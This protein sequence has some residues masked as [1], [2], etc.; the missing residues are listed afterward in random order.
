MQHQPPNMNTEVVD[1]IKEQVGEELG[2]LIVGE[3]TH[4]KKDSPF[5]S[6]KEAEENKSVKRDK[7]KPFKGYPIINVFKVIK[8]GYSY[9]MKNLERSGHFFIN[10]I[11]FLPDKKHPKEMKLVQDGTTTE[12]VTEVLINR[13]RYLNEKAPK[14][15]LTSAI[16]HYQH[17]LNQ[18]K[19]IK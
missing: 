5:L 11:R 7:K 12:A 3:E 10:F 4:I 15:E 2:N 9:R 19:R 1:K 14:E 6:M 16:M 8:R 17:A 13:L 18:L